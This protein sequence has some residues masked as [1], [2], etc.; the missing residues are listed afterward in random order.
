MMTNETPLRSHLLAALCAASLAAGCAA[1]G[2]DL[3]EYV[4]TSGQAIE[5][6][7]G[8]VALLLDLV[9]Y[10]GTDVAVLD[11]EARVDRRAAHNIIVHRNGADGVTPTADDQLFGSVE[12]LLAIHQV[13]AATIRKLRDFALESPAPAG[14]LV[15]GVKFRGWEVEAVVFGANH[16]SEGV[17][18]GLGLNSTQAANLVAGGPYA[19]VEAIGD[20]FYIGPRTLERL[21]GAAPAFWRAM[22]L[23]MGERHAGVFAGV[24]FDELTARAAL[25]IANRAS[26]DELTSDGGMWATGARR[27]VESRPYFTLAEVAEVHGVGTATMQSLRDYA[28]SDRW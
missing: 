8:D 28:S 14:E 10:P 18:K 23:G 13:G 5:L 20:V 21:R 4:D 26:F 2:D 15:Q 22:E 9:N 25:D 1:A 6:G 16:A 12:E 24:A 19:S 17:F 27:I 3:V 7:A 11:L